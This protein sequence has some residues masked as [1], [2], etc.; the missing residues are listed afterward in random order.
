[1]SFRMESADSLY[2]IINLG[3]EVGELYSLIAKAIRDQPKEDYEQNVKKELGDILWHIAAIADDFKLTLEEV[4]KE[5]INK[6]A[7]RKERNVI[8]GAGDNR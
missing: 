3:G 5:N 7:S 2:A 4:A 8:S 6:L 1:M